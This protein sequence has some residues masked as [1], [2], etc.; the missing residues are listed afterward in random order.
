MIPGLRTIPFVKASACGNDFL[1][2]DAALVPAAERASVTRSMCH[3]YQG[4]GADGVEWMLPHATAEIEI[5]LIN[6]D[7]S[8]AEISGNGTRCV[9]AYLFSEQQTEKISIQTGAGLKTCTLTSRGESEY[10]FEMAMGPA[11]V[12]KELLVRTSKGEARGIPLSTGNPHYV[13]FVDGFPQDWQAQALEIQGSP[14]FSQGVNVEFVK[15]EGK[16]DVRARF[17]ERGA[18]ETQSS[19]TGSCASAVAA[20]ATGRAESP[21]KVHAPGGMQTVRQEGQNIFLRGPARL[22]CRGEFFLT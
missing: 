18:G 2:I 6:A 17:F 7:G 19:G 14:A 15:I 10:E 21:V 1:L 11:K 22:I 12:D 16:H 8:A 5:D 3:R 13:I 9:A 20:I 4:I